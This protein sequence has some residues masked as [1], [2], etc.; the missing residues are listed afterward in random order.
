MPKLARAARRERRVMS[1]PY[2]LAQELRTDP[3]ITSL[4]GPS[5]PD[6][7]G[8][9]GRHPG[10]IESMLE[11]LCFWVSSSCMNVHSST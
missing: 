9:T 5:I 3:Q 1:Q 7:P 4:H 6:G 8:G 10:V 2:L 11:I